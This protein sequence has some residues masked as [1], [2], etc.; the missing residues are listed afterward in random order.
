MAPAPNSIIWLFLDADEPSVQ[1]P[2][3]GGN[4]ALAAP[5]AGPDSGSPA[6]D[7]KI[8]LTVSYKCRYKLSCIVNVT[9]KSVNKL[10][11]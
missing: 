3:P 1:P 11:K 6:I 4:G 10:G 9:G 5:S 8:F 7:S 2:G